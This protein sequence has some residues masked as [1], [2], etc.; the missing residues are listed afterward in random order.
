MK[1]QKIRGINRRKC[2]IEK[3]GDNNKNLDV[4]LVKQAERDYVKFWV[5]PWS[6]LSLIDSI[7]PEPTGDCEYL[8]VKHLVKIYQSWK[9]SL[10]DMQ[11]PYYLQIWLYEKCISRSQV[12]CAIEGYK[13]FYQHTFER[14]DKQPQTGIQS[15][16]HYNSDTASLL[17]N[18]QWQLNREVRAYNMTDQDDIEMFAEIDR[19]KILRKEI[20]WGKEHQIVEID[21]VWLIL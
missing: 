2:A 10:E 3:W 9:D 4:D 19:S 13:D 7:N 8:L 5:Q 16:L 11:T 17:D 18:F 15:S 20:I 21:K 12:V 14:I 1:Y 6:R